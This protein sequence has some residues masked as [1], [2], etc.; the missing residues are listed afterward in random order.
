MAPKL[1][2]SRSIGAF[3]LG[4]IS[5]ISESV[6]CNIEQVRKI[7]EDIRLTLSLT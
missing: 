4:Q 7:D 5:R 3:D 6:K 1:L 2:G